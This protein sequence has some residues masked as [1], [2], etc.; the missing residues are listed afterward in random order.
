MTLSK[1]ELTILF[2][3][4]FNCAANRIKNSR[5]LITYESTRNRITGLD[6]QPISRHKQWTIIQLPMMHPFSGM[7]AGRRRIDYPMNDLAQIYAI[8]AVIETFCQGFTNMPHFNDNWHGLESE[9]RSDAYYYSLFF[10]LGR[11]F[12]QK[13]CNIKLIHRLPPKFDLAFK[14]LK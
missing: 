9:T 13:F 10:H 7:L 2:M 4:R 11:A 1:D 6:T 5:S 12:L 3:K 14:E 8:D